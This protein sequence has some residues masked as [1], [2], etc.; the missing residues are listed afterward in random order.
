MPELIAPELTMYDLLRIRPQHLR[1]VQIERDYAD[2]L[3]SAHYVVTPFVAGTFERL[4]Q[5]LQFCSTAR[6]WRLTGDYGSGKSSFML[7]FARYAARATEMLPEAL[8]GGTAP[9]RLEPVLVVGEREPIGLSVVRAL[10]Q[11]IARL[12]TNMPGAL[13][14]KF[15]AVDASDTS[16]LVELVASVGDWVR[17]T[18]P[19]Q[20][21]LVVFDEL[22][23]NLE[24]AAAAP[25]AGDLQLLQDLAEAAARSG[26]KP[27]VVVAVLHQ[28]VTAYAQELS[29]LER[30]EWEKV[31]GR[32]EEIVFAPPLEQGAGLTAAALGLDPRR[33]PKRLASQSRTQMRT[34]VEAGWY[35]PGANPATLEALATALAPLDAFVLPVLTRLLRRFGQNERSLFSFL[36]STEPGG[37]LAYASQDLKQYR[38]Y[39]LHHLYDY[40]A[41][42]LA[43]T[44]MRGPSGVRWNVVDSVVRSN[45]AA[46]EL[47]RDALK[48]VGLIN[49]LDEPC[50]TLTPHLLVN[51]LC[52]PIDR[53]SGEAA[54][55]RLRRDA[56]VLYDRGAGGGLCLWPHTSV[57]LQ[58]AFD[59]GLKAVARGK[60]IIAALRSVLPA[61]P[62]VA[63]R[64]YVTSGTMR[65]FEPVYAPVA[66]LAD[67]LRRSMPSDADGRLLVVMSRTERER[68]EALSLLAEHSEWPGTLVVGVPP[69]VGDLAPLLRDLDAWTW[70]S[71]ETP[72]LSGDRLAR[73]EVA[74]QI[75]LAEDRLR[76][77]LA[78]LLDFNA[79]QPVDVEHY[80]PKGEVED[81]PAHTGY[82]WLAMRWD[83]LLP[84]CI[85]CNRRRRQ[86][87]A[88]LG[89]TLDELEAEFHEG[90]TK[91]SGKKDAFPTRNGVWARTE[92]DTISGEQPLL[93]DP[94]R[95]SPEEHI[96]WPVDAEISV[97]VPIVDAGGHA[98]AEGVASIHVY[99]LN[100][101][102]LA[103]ER[104]KLLLEL[105]QR[106]AR[107]NQLL[108]LAADVT[109][110]GGSADGLL[111]VA[112]GLVEDILS[113]TAPD[114][115]YSALATAFVD[116]LKAKLA[117]Q[118]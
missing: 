4:M 52:D 1:S 118:T 65:H 16:S 116:R 6:A 25:H 32:F 47:E 30:R 56:R 82:W 78:A 114:Q 61:D 109:T 55:T 2:P 101:M 17:A 50:L 10:R 62:L 74:R 91:A 88:S 43:G 110:A 94:T 68:A 20:G 37:L 70:V 21:L 97:A 59:K 5:S 66:G 14:R 39:R 95:T 100:R 86:V 85:D 42:N 51:V 18:S 24:H 93:I 103:Q 60:D 29:S 67:A 77:A 46:N 13:A 106:E 26:T 75:A 73:E 64:H 80:R 105:R 111:R 35:G 11:T 41:Q 8:A 36:S 71:D 53:A 3:S 90:Q 44:L 99:G 108:D 12:A 96:A 117:A 38:P 23:K 28:A 84:S 33:V 58:D 76:R 81:D 57:D 49:L 15:G 107:I 54:V 27:I 34:A 40:M 115:R 98:S 89:M 69:T 7:A 112:D 102:G 63:R 31:S 72:A 87:T 92:A 48:V 79:S 19:S 113:L 45:A 9:V 104:T 83:N 22:G